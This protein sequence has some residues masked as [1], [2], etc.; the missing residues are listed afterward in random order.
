ASLGLLVQSF[1]TGLFVVTAADL[2]GPHWF[3]RL[4]VLAESMLAAGFIHLAWVFPTDRLTRRRG[5]ARAAIHGPVAPLAPASRPGL[6][7]AAPTPSTPAHPAPSARPGLG[8]GAI[9]GVMAYELW[10]TR[11]PLVR[12]RVGVVALGTLAAFALPGAL[13]AASAILGGSVPL[14]AGAF[15]AFVFPLSL[16]YAIVKQD[17]FEIDVLLRRGAPPALQLGARTRL[18]R[19]L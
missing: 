2:Y 14:N 11:S 7:R 12:R 4:H 3:F 13:M 19:S 9:I 15:T 17:L 18:R 5:A 16:G 6:P 1:T 10:T 8:A